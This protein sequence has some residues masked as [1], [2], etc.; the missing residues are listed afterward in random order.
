MLNSTDVFSLTLSQCQPQPEVRFS[1]NLSKCDQEELARSRRAKLNIHRRRHKPRSLLPE[2]LLV[3]S[4]S[5]DSS[6]EKFLPELQIK[7]TE[8]MKVSV[9]SKL[10]AHFMQKTNFLEVKT[11]T[12]PLKPILIKNSKWLSTEPDEV[13]K[14]AKS[15]HWEIKESMQTT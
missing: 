13:K 1:L 9:R 11:S 4:D 14:Q 5:D 3:S 15:V 12:K 8:M 6:C 2:E 7:K 10:T